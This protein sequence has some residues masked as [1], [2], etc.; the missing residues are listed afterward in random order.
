MNVLKHLS[1]QFV[2]FLRTLKA[3]HSGVKQAEDSKAR[4]GVTRRDPVEHVHP[5][6]RRHPVTGEEALY[7]NRGFTRRIIGLKDEESGTQS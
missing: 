2:D 1:P 7:I 6:I 3:V 5:L 4:G